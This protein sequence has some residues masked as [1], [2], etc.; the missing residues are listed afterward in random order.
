MDLTLWDFG[1]NGTVKLDGQWAFVADQ[2]LSPEEF[3]RTAEQAVMPNAAYIEVPGTWGGQAIEGRQLSNTGFG[4]YRLIVKLPPQARGDALALA[5]PSVATAYKLWIDGR[6]LESQGVVGRNRAEMTARNFSKIVYF[7]PRGDEAEI[8]LQVSNFVQ[9]KGGVWAGIKLGNGGQI[10]LERERRVTVQIAA[11]SGM[12]IMGL[13]HI[14]LYL[15][16]RKYRPT[17]LFGIASVL[18]CLRTLF[19]GDTLGVRLWPHIGWE[20]AV[21]IEYLSAF[22]GIGCFVLYTHSLYARDIG[23]KLAY[24]LFLAICLISVPV[25]CL[26]ANIY[27]QAMLFCQVVLVLSLVCIGVGVVKAAT[28]GRP[29]ARLNLVFVLLFFATVINDVFFY[30][31]IVDTGDLLPYGLYAVMFGQTIVLAS[32]FSDAFHQVE[33]LSAQLTETNR[34]LERKIG[35]RTE[36]LVLSNERLQQME[37]ARRSMLSNISHEFGTP[38][39][40]LIGYIMAM[41]EGVLSPRSDSYLDVVYE[42]ARMLQR[43]TEDLKSLVSLETQQMSF[44]VQPL[45]WTAYYG[46]IEAKY[47]IDIRK[48]DIVFQ[49]EPLRC[50]ADQPFYIVADIERIDQVMT[51]LIS[52][53]IQHTSA[54]KSIAISG[55]CFPRFRKCVI[56]V[57]DRGTGIPKREMP[58]LF[59]RFYKGNHA[60]A[61]KS[62]GSGLGLA[63]SKE[64]AERHGGRLG[65]RSRE[66]AGSTFYLVLPLYT[67][68]ETIDRTGRDGR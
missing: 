51:N 67:K 14:G 8:V 3:Q 12:L 33:N 59:E 43:L 16:R 66:G 6:L 15:F 26:P 49:L 50:A 68:E 47:G 2:L 10:A 36:A 35:E 40:S 25:A 24:G 44:H 11:A 64:I 28:R 19:V 62:A 31:F 5:M 22:L 21:K 57:T 61:R 1:A 32:R 63:I 55:R 18:I 27:T 37:R 48:H 52:N 17:L 23:R 54:D 41:K 58:Y 29:G 42:K 13:Y 7:T 9:R 30:N 4:T 60:P 46:S 38:L 65:M 39:T 45:E 53:A 56:A 20:L 34:T